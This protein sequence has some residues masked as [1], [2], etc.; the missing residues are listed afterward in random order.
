MKETVT[1]MRKHVYKSDVSTNPLENEQNEMI[2]QATISKL[3]EQME[4]LKSHKLSEEQVKE[5][6]NDI[7]T[8]SKEVESDIIGNKVRDEIKSFLKVKGTATYRELQN[9]MKTKN[10]DKKLF[11][12]LHKMSQEKVVNNSFFQHEGDPA[13]GMES[14]LKLL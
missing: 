5:L 13:I 7:L 6:V 11:D 14:E 10:M 4:E 3:S 12:E 1:D 8:K 9:Y 2:F